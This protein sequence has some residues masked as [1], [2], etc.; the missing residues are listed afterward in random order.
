MAQEP[1]TMCNHN[2]LGPDGQLKSGYDTRLNPD[3]TRT[4]AKGAAPMSTEQTANCVVVNQWGGTITN[5]QLRHRYSNNPSYQQQ[6]N[7]P[8]LAENVTSSSFQAIFWTGATGHDYWWVQFEDDNGKIWSCKQNFYC[9]LKSSDANT[10]VYFFLNG[11]SEQM[12]IQMISG[13]CDTSL[14]D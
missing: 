3:M 10:T 7:W 1:T 2:S 12:Q 6:G 14:S 9:T 5:V 11:S 8:S 4:A 13:G